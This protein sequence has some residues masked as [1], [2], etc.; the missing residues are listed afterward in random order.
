MVK[1]ADDR[2][3]G[4]G[5]GRLTAGAKRRKIRYVLEVLDEENPKAR[6]RKV[7]NQCLNSKIFL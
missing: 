7:S 4:E 1:V 5:V 6:K 3:E 2:I